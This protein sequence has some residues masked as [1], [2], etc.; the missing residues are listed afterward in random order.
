ME[1][2]GLSGEHGGTSTPESMLT[3][4]KRPNRLH[5]FNLP[6]SLKWGRQRRL[7]CIKSST[8]DNNCFGSRDGQS[9]TSRI[10]DNDVGIE[11]LT[12]KLTNDLK[13]AAKKIK[14]MILTNKEEEEKEEGEIL[15][16]VSVPVEGVK[17]WK[18]RTKR[19]EFQTPNRGSNKGKG[20][21]IGEKKTNGSP[22]MKT[23]TNDNGTKNFK[24]LRRNCEKVRPSMKF[25]LT[26]TKKEIEEDF[27]AITGHLPP[28]KP[29]KRPKAVQRQIDDL[30]LGTWLSEVDVDFYNVP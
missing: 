5:N 16:E 25:S 7:R 12:E 22:P 10:N 9:S 18:K 15:P 14:N 1:L 11:E 8:V 29:I 27:L 4:P 20:L 19:E 24:N 23:N 3:S 13:S 26:L 21:K 28:K 17:P 2:K 30:Y 6:L